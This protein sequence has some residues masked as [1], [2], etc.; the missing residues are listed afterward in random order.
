MQSGA[1]ATPVSKISRWVGLILSTL[2]VM[3][4][5]FDGVIKVLQLPVAVDS[6]TQLGYAG[7]LVIAI[8]VIELVFLVIYVIPWTSVLGA[9]LLTGY[10]G[11]AIATQIRAGAPLFSII[12][13]I[14]IAL[15]LWRGLFL[16]DGRLRALMPLRR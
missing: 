11:G 2:A 6:T 13:P 4:L 14:F 16:L 3:F 10:L 5:I 1:Q 7:E 9:L 15:F 8:G 12:F